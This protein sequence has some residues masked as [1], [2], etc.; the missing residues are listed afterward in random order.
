[1]SN[2]KIWIGLDMG[3]NSIGWMVATYN[4]KGVP[5]VLGAG[6][7]IFEPNK[8]LASERRNLRRQRRHIRATRTR[9]RRIKQYLLQRGIISRELASRR[10]LSSEPWKL[11]A[12]VLHKGDLLSAHDFLAV[13]LWYAHNRGYDGNRLW[14]RASGRNRNT[15]FERENQNIEEQDDQ[16][17]ATAA[18]EA[19]HKTQQTTMAETVLCLVTGCLTNVDTALAKPALQSYK[20][21]N[22]AFPR[23]TVSNEVA[24]IVKA[25]IGHLPGLTSDVAHLILADPLEEPTALH[26]QPGIPKAYLGGY[27]FGQIRPR[28]DNRIIP[29]CPI[30]N[31]KVPSKSSDAFLAFRWAELL[32]QVRVFHNG[33][34][35]TLS[36][37]EMKGLSTHLDKYGRFTPGDFKNTI[38]ELTRCDNDN[39]DALLST[40]DVGTRLIRYPGRAELDK[41]IGIDHFKQD[42]TTLALL[43]RLTHKLARGKSIEQSE[44]IPLLDPANPL[45]NKSLPKTFSA[46][47]II[48][49]GRAPYA[50]D[51]LQKATQAILNGENPWAAETPTSKA[52]ILY[53]NAWQMDPLKEEDIDRATNNHLVRHR[54]KILLRLLRD[55]TKHY[56]ENNPDRIERICLEVARNIRDFSGKTA[57]IIEGEQTLMRKAH[58][59]AIKQLCDDLDLSSGEISGNLARKMRIAQDLNFTCPYTGSKFDAEDIASKHVDLDHILPYSQRQTNALNALVLTFSEVNRT[60]G[61]RTALQFIRECGGMEISVQTGTGTRV[62][63][64]RHEDS[65]RAAVKALKSNHPK[66]SDAQKIFESRKQKLLMLSAKEI[67]EMPDGMLTQTRAC[68]I[69]AARAIQGWFAARN[70]RVRGN[71]ILLIPSRITGEIRK[72]YPLF[73]TLAQFDKRLLQ[74][75]TTQDANPATNDAFPPHKLRTRPKGEIRSISHMHHAVD[76][77]LFTLSGMLFPTEHSIWQLMLKRHHTPKEQAFLRQK[78]VPFSWDSSGHPHFDDLPKETEDSIRKALKE[79]RTVFYTSKRLGRTELEQTQWRVE[80]I[81]NGRALIRQ[82]SPKGKN[83]SRKTGEKSLSALYGLA[84]KNG[85]GKLKANQ[86]VYVGEAN[87]AIAYYTN[88]ATIQPV[89]IRNRFVWQQIQKITTEHGGQPPHLLH[90]GDLI[91]LNEGRYKGVWRVTSIKDNNGIVHVDLTFPYNAE[92]YKKGVPYWKREVIFNSLL[93]CKSFAH[94]H[95]DLTGVPACPIT[96][97]KSQ[98]SKKGNSFAETTN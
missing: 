86:A 75:I 81:E 23:E 96:S 34:A 57:K 30:S 77:I 93:K 74:E 12:R 32:S 35:H 71:R 98:D 33:T 84:P 43:R 79:Q 80:R 36:P 40:P 37:Y 56:A 50:K 16:K 20:A 27:I 9:I 78:G 5:H 58:E 11:A 45:I 47:N 49:A 22:M 69:L 76:A 29:L 53:R 14:S 87:F 82:R 39:L 51:I 95:P 4:I 24:R 8:C 1:M 92:R 10:H 25:H 85:Q 41:S 18:N 38:R 68:T 64:L 44:L 62:V 66:A 70:V 91:S 89:I 2:D 59:K 52:G 17:K 63:Q 65:Y 21:S 90:K 26:G 83:A 73:G 6:S 67:K 13:L 60:K 88:L 31:Q 7:V 42:P 3:Y 54:T 94:L 48:P 28:F 46:V 15:S 97:S 72:R 61:N 19:M 55:I